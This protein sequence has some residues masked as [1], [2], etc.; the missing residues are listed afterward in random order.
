MTTD[1]VIMASS[2]AV[3]QTVRRML[4]GG[5]LCRVVAY[6]DA[7]TPCGA[8]IARVRPDLILIGDLAAPRTRLARIREA[9]SAAPA[10]KIVL[11]VDSMDPEELA[12]AA[13]AGIDA[14]I[15][16]Q[17]GT[18]GVAALI[19]EVAAGNVYHAFAPRR[20]TETAK[21]DGLTPRELEILRLVAAGASNGRIARTLWVAEQTVKYH[22]SN[23]Y[24]K[25]GVANRTQASHYAHVHRL[26]DPPAPTAAERAAAEEAA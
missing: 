5:M 15:G 20:T 12:D 26:V 7:G 1:V 8:A 9:R 22:L 6:V 3:C 16:T 21:R 23:I 25:L 14:A 4:A 24:R 19:H 18:L 11:L 2:P 13:A 10:A 17:A